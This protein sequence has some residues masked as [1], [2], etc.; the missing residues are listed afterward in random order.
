MSETELP[1]S[2]AQLFVQQQICVCGKWNWEQ[3]THNYKHHICQSGLWSLSFETV[4]T[5]RQVPTFRGNLSLRSAGWKIGA[6][7]PFERLTTARFIAQKITVTLVI[8]TCPRSNQVVCRHSL[9]VCL[10]LLLAVSWPL[11]VQLPS[12]ARCRPAQQYMPCWLVP[13]CFSAASLIVWGIPKCL[14]L[15]K[16]TIMQWIHVCQQYPPIYAQFSEVFILQY[17]IDILHKSFVS[18]IRSTRPPTLH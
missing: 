8:G 17:P 3:G 18:L 9:P 14:F 6:V 2:A 13:R 4:Q 1:M 10:L 16:C 7:R 5:C 15:L 12:L 11:S